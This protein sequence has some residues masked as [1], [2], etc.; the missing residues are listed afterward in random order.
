MLNEHILMPIF[1][2]VHFD[3]NHKSKSTHPLLSKKYATHS[4]LKCLGKVKK[5]EYIFYILS[6]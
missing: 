2:L 6:A 1:I 3:L 4:V 5:I